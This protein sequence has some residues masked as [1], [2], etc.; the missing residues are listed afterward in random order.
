MFL[1]SDVLGHLRFQRGFQR[2]LGQ[3]VEQPTRSDQIGALFLGLG[4][5]LLG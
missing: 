3:L 2:G 5:Q 1:I 4:Q